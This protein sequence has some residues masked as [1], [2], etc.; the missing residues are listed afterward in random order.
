MFTRYEIGAFASL[1]VLEG[2]EKTTNILNSLKKG[3]A[4]ILKHSS[5]GRLASVAQLDGLGGGLV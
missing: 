4:G 1:G 2:D 5:L 3:R